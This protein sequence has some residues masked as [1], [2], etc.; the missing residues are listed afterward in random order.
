MPD[1]RAEGLGQGR[2]LLCGAAQECA[3]NRLSFELPLPHDLR[4]L[5]AQPLNGGET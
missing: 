4:V 5:G 1:L 2:V 3:P